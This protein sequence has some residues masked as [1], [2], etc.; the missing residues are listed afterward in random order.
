MA[1]R[2]TR[3]ILILFINDPTILERWN[4]ECLSTIMADFVL[5]VSVVGEKLILLF[6]GGGQVI[7]PS[8]FSGTILSDF[9]IAVR[10]YRRRVD[11][12]VPCGS[13]GT[14]PLKPNV[15]QESRISERGST[16]SPN[17]RFVDLRRQFK[18]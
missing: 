5:E 15:H 9:N 12:R 11:A 2:A 1:W 4:D 7:E 10:D 16:A 3:I 6:E 13:K 17:Y 8:T 14:Q 18:L